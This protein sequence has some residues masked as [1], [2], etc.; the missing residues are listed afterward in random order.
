MWNNSA[1]IQLC[2]GTRKNR[3]L[4]ASSSFIILNFLIPTW[5]DRYAFKC[6]WHVKSGKGSS[7]NLMWRTSKFH[8]LLDHIVENCIHLLLQVVCTFLGLKDAKDQ[9]RAGYAARMRR[10]QVEEKQYIRPRTE[11]ANESSN[12][13]F[14]FPIMIPMNIIRS[15][16][17]R[18]GSVVL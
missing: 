7:N 17:T 16:I 4:L 10:F 1:T 15:V 12:F 13:H 2:T 11:L 5:D 14:N 8:F 9:K 3:D 6:H 18:Q